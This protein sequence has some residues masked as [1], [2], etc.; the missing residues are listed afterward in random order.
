MLQYCIQ[1]GENY[2]GNDTEMTVLERQRVRLMWLQ[3]QQQGT[4]QQQP[5]QNFVIHNNPMEFYQ[6][7]LFHSLVNNDFY[8]LPIPKAEFVRDEMG[9]ATNSHEKG[10]DSGL[11]EKAASTTGRENLKKRKAEKEFADG[12]ENK[13]IRNDTEEVQS[14]ITENS[15]T[16][17]ENSK[18]QRTDFIHVRARR[19]QATDSH[20]LA[21]RAR[22]EKIGKKM[23]CLQ[24]LVP[25]C[26]K[27][28]GKAGMLDEIIN[29]VQ[30]LQR[31]VEFLS[32]KLAAFNPRPD[33]NI[34]N[35]IAK[36]F[37]AYVAGF[38]TTTSPSSGVSNLGYLQFNPMQQGTTSSSIPIPEQV[39][40]FPAMDTGLQSLYNVEFH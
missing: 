32:M 34:D 40:P 5:Q 15:T 23:K 36:E 28:T 20:S 38:P 3:Q 22:R 14:K 9:F 2:S 13:R 6:T 26:E 19:G 37:P 12:P 17:M 30:S 35:F 25:G 31:Q 39:P 11:T 33:F 29:Y 7:P 8:N 18:V 27:I 24:D 4:Y 10:G 16:C 1:S 21:E